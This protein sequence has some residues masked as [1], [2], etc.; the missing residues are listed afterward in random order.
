[1]TEAPHVLESALL[2]ILACPIDKGALIYLPDEGLLYNPRLRRAY[3]VADGL[4]VM[5][6]SQ[7]IPVPAGQHARLL[8]RVGRGEATATGGMPPELVA[9]ERSA[10][11]H[12]DE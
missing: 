9:T 6:V 11:G 1:M 4:P 7:A 12:A 5:L 2:E 10:I 3:Q 8:D